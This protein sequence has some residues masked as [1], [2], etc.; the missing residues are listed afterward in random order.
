MNESFIFGELEPSQYFISKN[1][2]Q[3]AIDMNRQRE[4]MTYYYKY[5]ESVLLDDANK[6]VQDYD[7]NGNELVHLDFN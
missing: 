2:E 4:P 7:I 5:S 1:G 3:E 6:P